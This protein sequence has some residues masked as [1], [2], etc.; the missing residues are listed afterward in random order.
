[1][2]LQLDFYIEKDNIMNEKCLK[3]NQNISEALQRLKETAQPLGLSV[4]EGKDKTF[5]ICKDS[6]VYIADDERTANAFLHGI[7][8]RKNVD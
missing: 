4:C 5:L 6:I 1:M 8:Y 2:F 7:Y 3:Q